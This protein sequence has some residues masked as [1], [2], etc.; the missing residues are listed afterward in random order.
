MREV[1]VAEA[2]KQAILGYAGAA[3]AALAVAV[4]MTWPLL[5]RAASHV[6]EATCYWDAY[7]N[8][9]ILSGRVDAMLGRGPLSLYDDYFFAPLPN[10]IVFNENLF[11]LSLIFAPF[12]LLSNSPLWA[13]NLTLVTSLALSAFFTYLLVRR[14]TGSA[15]AGVLAGVAFAFC[16]YVM[17][18]L[19]RIQLVATQWIPASL[20]MLHRAIERG[21]PLD[22]VGLWLAYLLQIGTCLYYALFLLPLLALVGAVL[23]ARRRPPRELLVKLAGAGA[24]AAIVAWLMVREYFSVRGAFALERSPTFA[25]S[26][27]GKLGFFLNVAETNRSLTSL[28]HRGEMRGVHEEIAFPGFVVL[29]LL[30]VSLG[31][32]LWREI[33]DRSQRAARMLVGRWLGVVAGALLVTLLLHSML[34][35]ALA[36][37]LGVVWQVRARQACPFVGTRGLYFGVLVLSIA[38]FLGLFPFEWAGSPVRGLYYYLYSYI[39]G[40]D[41]IRKVSRQAVVTSFAFV[42]VA[43]FGSAWLFSRMKTERDK[44]VLFGLLLVATL[45]ELRS[46][47][48]PVH[49]EWAAPDVP[50]VYRFVRSLPEKDLVAAIPQD[51]GATRFRND[52]GRALHNY[53]M[54]LHK[55]RSLNGQSSYVLPVTDLVERVSRHL[56]DDGARRVLEALGARHLIVHAGDLD[57]ARRDL[58]Q[59]LA[60][61]AQ[62]YQSAFHR[63]DDYVFSLKPSKDPTLA[64]LPTPALPPRAELVPRTEL[65]ASGI[66]KSEYA[67]KSLDGS[68]GTFWPGPEAQAS[69][70]W[71]ELALAEPRK[72]LALDFENRQHPND[73]PLSFQVAVGTGDEPLRTVAEQPVVRVFHDQIYSPKTFV[74]RVVIPEPGAVDRIRVTIA[75]PLPGHGFKVH[76]ARIWAAPR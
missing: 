29:G 10:S 7:T 52:A 58:P 51:D 31:G 41:G 28:H 50:D 35:G 12:Y 74:W 56:P 67:R 44:A 19:G 65:R 68:A 9:M 32:P 15:Y 1:S 42:L 73:L 30:V 59:R 54:A 64:L 34:A 3:L 63:G 60:A 2:R 17:F 43:S 25:A 39:P 71:F 72:V 48:H 18:E 33:R 36:F 47:P 75:Q 16:P 40:F 22:I 55:H 46:F 11:G 49:A 24:L 21:K 69:G 20:L 57:A 14:L 6:L 66:Q 8:A 70:Q 27:D 76:E 38:L 23:V 53:L 26:Y 62:H 37:A 61:D 13:Y 5:P 45:F 4:I